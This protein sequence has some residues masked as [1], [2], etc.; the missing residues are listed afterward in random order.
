MKD[1]AYWRLSDD[2]KRWHLYYEPDDTY[3]ATLEF[4]GRNFWYNCRIEGTAHYHEKAAGI[5]PDEARRYVQNVVFGLL[6]KASGELAERIDDI[7]SRLL[8]I[9]LMDVRDDNHGRD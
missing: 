1:K 5:T 8:A 7:T 2:G 4:D 6:V 9:Y 3:I